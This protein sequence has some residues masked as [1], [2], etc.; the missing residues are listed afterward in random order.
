[1]LSVAELSQI[2]RKS[3]ISIRNHIKADNK[4]DYTKEEIIE[5]RNK[6]NERTKELL[7]KS[8]ETT[9][10]GAAVLK[11]DPKVILVI[12]VKGVVG[13]PPKKKAILKN[14]RLDRL[15]AASFI[16]A[17]KSTKAMLKLVENYVT[18]GYPTVSTVTQLLRHRGA[19]NLKGQRFKINNFKQIALVL[20][21]YGIR[22]VE[23]LANEIYFAGVY[24][25]EANAC[26]WPFRLCPPSNGLGKKKLHFV[27]NGC[28][29]NRA[30]MIN[31]MVKKMI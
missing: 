28:Y 23:E 16:R 26:L 24:F 14:L 17:N 3:N 11:E 29:G 4:V 9:A 25:K 7:A 8:K 13:V 20:G 5:I 12:R 1:M 6:A 27:D 18:Y 2:T 21:N 10:T 22:C 30:E 31:D 19:I 15:Y